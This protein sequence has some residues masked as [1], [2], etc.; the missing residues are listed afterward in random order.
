MSVRVFMSVFPWQWRDGSLGHVGPF[1]CEGGGQME[2]GPEGEVHE[3][4]VLPKCLPSRP[5]KPH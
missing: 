1:L 4:H 2:G 5:L 3:G